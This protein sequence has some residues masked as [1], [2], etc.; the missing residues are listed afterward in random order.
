MSNIYKDM[1]TAIMEEIQES[2]YAL[3]NIRT[4]ANYAGHLKRLLSRTQLTKETLFLKKNQ[5]KIIS[6]L[7][8]KGG[9]TRNQICCALK[10]YSVVLDIEEA[11]NFSTQQMDLAIEL[12]KSKIEQDRIMNKKN[13]NWV[14]FNIIKFHYKN[15]LSF[16]RYYNQIKEHKFTWRL[17]TKTF[18]AYERNLKMAFHLGL[19]VSNIQYNPPRRSQDWTL[20]K[21]IPIGMVKNI[22]EKDINNYCVT[23]RGVPKQVIFLKYKTSELYGKQEFDLNTDLQ[24]IMRCWISYHQEV[25]GNN[26][27]SHPSG[28]AKNPSTF[29]KTIQKVMNDFVVGEKNIKVNM[30]RNICITELYKD[31]DV[32]ALLNMAKMCGH[33]L[34]TAK[35]HYIKS[36]KHKIELVEN[37]MT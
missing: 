16:I 23:I 22:K 18:P 8:K 32:D 30:L 6:Y 34:E 20:M 15:A 10:K 21:V 36:N 33:T 17:G 1:A 2:K 5:D 11:I 37:L 12:R 19:Y 26:L 28:A 31:I 24:F 35:E 29:G 4:A 27:I 14:D 13:E 9:S 3:K 25:P 7:E